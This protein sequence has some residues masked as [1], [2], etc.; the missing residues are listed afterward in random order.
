[1]RVERVEVQVEGEASM[2]GVMGGEGRDEGRARREKVC[3]GMGVW[4]LRRVVRMFDPL[5]RGQK[6]ERLSR[7]LIRTTRPVQPT[8][9]AENDASAIFVG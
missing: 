5:G 6:V 3:V 9:A 7:V 8:T 1:M 2:W 4:R